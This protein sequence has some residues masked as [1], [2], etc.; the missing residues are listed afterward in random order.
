MCMIVSRFSFLFVFLFPVTC[1]AGAM[2]SV[3]ARSFAYA[4]AVSS[5][6]LPTPV[7]L[8]HAEPLYIDLIRDLG[9]LKG[10]KEWNIGLGLTD[11][12]RYDSYTALVEYEFAPVNRLGLEIEMPFTF[13]MPV[14]GQGRRDS[15]PGSK[16]NSLKLAGQ[17]SFLVSE[18]LQTSIALGYIHELE[19][20]A[21]QQYKK[22]FAL[23]GHVYNPFVVAAR[24]W[25]S[26]L[27]SLLYTGPVIAKH[28]QRPA[29]VSWQINTSMHYMIP[30]TRNFIGVEFNKET[31]RRD[32]D[33]TIRPQLRVSVADNLL[34][35]I[36]TGVP[37]KREAERFSTFIRLI[38]EPKHKHG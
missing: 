2:N 10:E 9:A 8:H 27:H 3:P 38:Y 1:F 30:G 22:G 16:L 21:F 24:R 31:T 12:N 36:V 7:K 29:H 34:V 11:H 14:H 23:Q 28:K 17:W 26:H 4:V 6:T 25:G 19:L 32:F 18:K 35:G 13:Y 15:L 20:P 37:I 33:M 5:D